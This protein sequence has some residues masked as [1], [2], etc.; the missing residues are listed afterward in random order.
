MEKHNIPVLT[1]DFCVRSKVQKC[2]FVS[3]GFQCASSPGDFAHLVSEGVPWLMYVG[4]P[5]AGYV[6]CL[7]NVSIP[8]AS[9][10]AFLSMGVGTF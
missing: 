5:L 1:R 2:F 6:A 4:A 9:D 3:F 7:A 10:C 8:Y